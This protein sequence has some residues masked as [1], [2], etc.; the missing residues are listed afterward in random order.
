VARWIPEIARL[1]PE[2]RHAP[3]LAPARVLEEAGVALDDDY[4]RPIVEHASA[5]ERALVAFAS[6][7]AR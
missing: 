7:K 6:I 3:W 1:P 2:H 4:P 5:R